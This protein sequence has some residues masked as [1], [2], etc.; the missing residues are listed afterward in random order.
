MALM[1]WS[2]AAMVTR[3]QQLSGT[4]RRDVA[5]QVGGLLWADA[6]PSSEHGIKA[7]ETKNETRRDAQPGR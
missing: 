2:S 5:K 7:N 1:G 3:Y 6:G 4:I